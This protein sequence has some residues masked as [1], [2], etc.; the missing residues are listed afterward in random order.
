MGSK[1]SSLG[2]RI[3]AL[4]VGPVPVPAGIRLLVAVGRRIAGKSD[5]LLG[6]FLKKKKWGGGGGMVEK[7]REVRG[8]AI[9]DCPFFPMPNPAW[10][11]VCVPVCAHLQGG[12]KLY[13]APA[14]PAGFFAAEQAALAFSSNRQAQGG[15]G[16]IESNS[17]SGGKPGK[18]NSAQQPPYLHTRSNVSVAYRKGLFQHY[19]ECISE[20]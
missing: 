2:D 19:F 5:T 14:Q 4:G 6:K 18:R 1:A 9:S 3:W 7:K 16:E 13:I 17:S 12:E 15:R 11:S 8:V 20:S 10:A